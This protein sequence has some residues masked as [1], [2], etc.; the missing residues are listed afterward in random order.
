LKPLPVRLRKQKTALDLHFG[1]V[2]FVCACIQFAICTFVGV[3][4]WSTLGM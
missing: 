2:G 3:V 1:T 4:K